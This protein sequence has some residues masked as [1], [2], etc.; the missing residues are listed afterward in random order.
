MLTVL[1]SIQF[2]YN[3]ITIE[4]FFEFITEKVAEFNRKYEFTI[5]IFSRFVTEGVAEFNRKWKYE[6]YF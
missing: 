4:I 1:T 2:S 6:F 3:Y 5:D